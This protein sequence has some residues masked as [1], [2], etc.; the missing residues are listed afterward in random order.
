MRSFFVM[1]ALALTAVSA[2][3]PAFA[4]TSQSQVLPWAE[5]FLVVQQRIAT[6]TGAMSGMST[7]FRAVRSREELL[8]ATRD[9]SPRIVEARAQLAQARQVLDGIDPLTGDQAIA[10]LASA[11]LTDTRNLVNE[12]DTL[13]ADVQGLEAAIVANNANRVQQIAERVVA[14]AILL[15]RNQANVVRT[16]QSAFPVEESD[17]HI[18]GS[19]ASM[20]IGMV[21]I[22]TAQNA[23]DAASI[24]AAA[25]EMARWNISARAALFAQRQGLSSLRGN[26]RTLEAGYL[27]FNDQQIGVLEEAATTIRAAADAVAASAS[28]DQVMAF[29][30][31]LG[32]YDRRLQESMLQQSELTLET[33]R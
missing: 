32:E 20:Y 5:Q 16:R 21:S 26:A 30:R 1:L 23:G 15:V 28:R 6:A 24:R 4:Q 17:H 27:D 31:P 29:A 11:V 10:S 8:V 7:A 9:L 2:P 18:L 25:D 14:G 3:A 19:V 13:F 33:L 12:L 22:I